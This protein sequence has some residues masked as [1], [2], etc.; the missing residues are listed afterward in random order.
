MISSPKQLL[1]DI[2]NTKWF[3]VTLDYWESVRMRF[4][5]QL[6][7]RLEAFE[8]WVLAR[9]LYNISLPQIFSE[10]PEIFCRVP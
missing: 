5:Y 7:Y 2:R 9:I 4:Y 6:I 10:F 3:E 8:N 1:A